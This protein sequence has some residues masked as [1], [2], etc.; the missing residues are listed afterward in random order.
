MSQPTPAAVRLGNVLFRYRSY[1]P[2]P[3][4]LAVVIFA[5]FDP[6]LLAAGI[7]VVICGEALRFAG[8]GYAGYATRTTTVGASQLV[9]AGPFAHVRNPLYVGN[10][11]LGLGFTLGAGG[12]FPWLPLGYLVLT[13]VYYYFI[14]RAEEQFL[15]DKFGEEYAGFRA[16]V[17]RFLPRITAWKDHSQHTWEGRVARRSERRTL[18]TIF[19]VSLLVCLAMVAKTFWLGWTF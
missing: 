19:I 14:V 10:I 8:V 18:Q 13:C 17:P 3:F 16:H 6:W 5:R 15:V 7:V 11:L 12:L 9:T 1:I 2:I 4:F